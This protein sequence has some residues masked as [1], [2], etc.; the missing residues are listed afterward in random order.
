M[1]QDFE[2]NFQKYRKLYGTQSF[3]GYITQTLR[4]LTKGVE[5][6]SKFYNPLV[7]EYILADIEEFFLEHRPTLRKYL[8]VVS[9]RDLV[10]DA[11]ISYL[12]MARRIIERIETE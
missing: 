12:A 7:D 9:M 4:V 10:S 1:K 3:S 6:E 2:N 5:D 8:R 11:L